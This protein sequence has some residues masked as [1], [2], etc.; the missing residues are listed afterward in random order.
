[1]AIA[2]MPSATGGATIPVEAAAIAPA[3]SAIGSQALP[4]L[5]IVRPLSSN[6]KTAKTC[7]GF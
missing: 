7:K 1:M 3:N 5:P 2:A 4:T 6:W